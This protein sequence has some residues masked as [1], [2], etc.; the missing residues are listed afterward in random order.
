MFF[1]NYAVNEK[2]NI[3]LSFLEKSDSDLSMKTDLRSN[4]LCNWGD[5]IGVIGI[6]IA[7]QIN[8]WNAN[9][10][11]IALEAVYLERLKED[12]A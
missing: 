12:I 11:D 2:E 9:R 10:K 1:F 4:P 3:C 7:L 8:Q 6:L 5:C